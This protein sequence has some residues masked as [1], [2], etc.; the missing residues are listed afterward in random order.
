MLR[1]PLILGY[2]GISRVDPRH[3]PDRLFVAPDR[4]RAQVERVCDRGYELVTMAEFARRLAASG[5]P[6]R[7]CALTFDD[8]TLDNLEEL[9]PILRDLGVPGTVYA[10]PGLL[11]EPYPWADAAAGARFMSAGELR[12][13]A[14]DPLVEV[15]SHTREHVDM[16][17]AGFEGA[18]EEMAE[19]RRDAR[20][21]HIRRGRQLRVPALP[22]LARLPR[23]GGARRLHQRRDLRRARRLEPLHAAPRAGPHP[24][25]A[26]HVRAQV[27]RPLPRAA[28]HAPR[29]PG[30]QRDPFLP[31]PRGALRAV[32]VEESEWI[33][34]ALAS[35]DL[36]AGASVLD[37]GSQTLDYRTREQPYVDANVIAPLRERGLE[38][39]HLDA[40]A[41]EGVDVVQDLTATDPD[42]LTA[43]GRR[44]DLVICAGTLPYVDDLDTAVRNVAALVAPGGWLLATATERYRL[45]PDPI[46]N[47]WRP[48][49]AEL[50][51]AF[52]RAEPALS[53]VREG[54]VRVDDPRYYKGWISRPSWMP[55]DGRA[56]VG[57][58]AGVHRPGA[59]AASRPCTGARPA[60]SCGGADAPP[61]RLAAQ[62]PD[63][64][65]GRASALTLRLA[66]PPRAGLR[67]PPGRAPCGWPTS[68]TRG[69]ARRSRRRARVWRSRRPL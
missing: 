63:V 58:V 66:G 1:P 56:L 18:L 12:E 42:P 41:A 7:T 55:R 39:T 32:Y 29:P 64:R 51:E 43:L 52:S 17:A 5:P 34:E 9:L 13:L 69:G 3:D 40:K 65:G 37:V 30:A 61:Q 11:G 15:G 45:E 8:G 31:P 25:R 27:A 4:F 57:S 38:V 22:V 21:A 46:D 16:D 14:R 33:R 23:G 26:R 53:L 35:V 10:C 68:A 50:G 6:P 24:R 20:G 19:S 54:V 44:F 47:R 2:H 36:A 48:T 49:P 59:Q 28:R 62:R 60:R 67:R